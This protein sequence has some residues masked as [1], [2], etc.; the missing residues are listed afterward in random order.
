MEWPL[1]LGTSIKDL[2]TLGEEEGLALMWKIVEKG[3]GFKL[4]VGILFRGF[5]REEREFTCLSS[6]IFSIYLEKFRL[7]EP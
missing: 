3:G 1:Y 2:C 5:L 4:K 6:F 7:F